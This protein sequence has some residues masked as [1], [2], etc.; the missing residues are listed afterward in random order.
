MLSRRHFINGTSATA[1]TSATLMA[2]T[3]PAHPQSNPRPLKFPRFISTWKF[4]QAVNEAALKTVQQGGSMLDA[5]EKG[6]WVA[7]A[8]A[9]NA[10]VGLGGIPAANG[11]VQLDACLM[12][13]P[14]HN[15]G[16]VAGIEDILHPIS[17]ARK[18]MEQT[19]H[20]MLV[21]EGA[22]QFALDHGFEKTN[23][24]TDEQ[25]KNYEEF[26]KKQAAG[27]KEE[28]EV[29]E[30]HHDTIALLGVDGD[31]NLYGGCS[32]SGWGFKVPGRVGDSPIIGSGLY[33][34]NEVGAAGA[35][36]IGENVMRHCASFMI[37]EEMRHGASPQQA[38][39]KVIQRIAKK[40]PRDAEKL[41]INF[42]AINRRG[43]TGAAGTSKGFAYA[44]TDP[45]ASKVHE[46]KALTDADIVEGGNQ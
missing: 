42:V 29:D 18:V 17:V 20:V 14:D 30:N 11:R 8:D 22:R 45:D 37:V 46:A 34:D 41:A 7:E 15:A 44:V 38:I 40:D 4:G 5:I 27:R 19:I 2:K 10:S 23:L 24:L 39:E 36:G 1:L 13:G 3:N 43:E 35:T 9:Q 28:Q 16:A 6:I 25:K 12:T 26:L 33:L 31:G 21:G 32:T